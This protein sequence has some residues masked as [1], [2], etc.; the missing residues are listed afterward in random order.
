MPVTSENQAGATAI[1]PFTMPKVPEAELEALRERIAATR[2]PSKELVADR[3]QGVQLATI[4]ELARYWAAD[5]DWRKC[6]AAL[7]ALPQFKTEIDGVDIHFIH[8]KSP[9]ANALPLIITHGWPG[10]V[11]ELLET[12]GPLTDPTAHGGAT[13]DAF[14]LVLPSLP[15]FGFSAEPTEVGWDPS[16]IAQAWAELMHRLGYTRYVAQGGDLGAYVCDEMGRQAPAGLLASTSTCSRR[17]WSALRQRN[18]PSRNVP[19]WQRSPPCRPAATAISSSRPPGRRRSATPCWIHRSPWRPG[20]STTTPTATTRSPAPSSTGS[21]RAISPGTDR[22]QHHAVLADRHRGLGRP[23]VLGERA[24]RSPRGRAGPA[25]GLGPGRLHRLPR[26]DLPGP[27]QLGPEGL[28]QPRLLPRGRQGRPLRRLGRARTVH[29]RNPGSVQA[30]ALTTARHQPPASRGPPHRDDVL[31]NITLYW[32]PAVLG[33]RG[34]SACGLLS[35]AR[36]W[37]RR[38][39][40]CGSRSSGRTSRERRSRPGPS[41]GP[42]WPV[43]GSCPQMSSSRVSLCTPLARP[44]RSSWESSGA[45][46]GVHLHA[47]GPGALSLPATR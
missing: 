20:C 47:P 23:G 17:R 4:Q 22:R 29:D 39:R 45:I 15:G 36:W 6:E 21:P 2:W 9:H 37:W 34:D 7:N 28:P 14:D 42:I 10:S 12:V 44:E 18:P 19:R 11:M 41:A 1:R 25:A 40:A 46:A 16:H 32:L 38:R 5:Y 8:V 33:C 13:S 30:I 31:D 35:W 43:S 3:S 24:S 26:R 27:A